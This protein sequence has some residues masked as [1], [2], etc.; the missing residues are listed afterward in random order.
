MRSPSEALRVR[1]PFL[2]ALAAT[3][4][5]AA[6]SPRLARSAECPLTTPP[7]VDLRSVE[8]APAL[9]IRYATE[10]NFTGDAL[11]G[12]ERARALL[13]PDA[14]AALERVAARLRQD[15]LGLK[16]WDAYRPERASRAMVAWARRSGREWVIEQGYVAPESG[17][18]RGATIDLTLVRLDTGEELDMGTPYDTFTEDAHTARA[19]G[20]VLENRMR[21][22]RA[23][24][25]EG[26]ENYP[27]E[28]WH[29]SRASTAAPMDIPLTCFP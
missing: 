19:S 27:L 26:W 23:M 28:W 9:E 5:L 4:L 7:M 18:N 8:P 3:L 2:A 13:R 1:G 14:A 16:V 25:E 29:F 10:D 21:L 12:Y 6:C 17:H 22:V 24:R 11:P 20:E 15:G